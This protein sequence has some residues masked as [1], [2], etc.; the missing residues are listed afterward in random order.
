V[1]ESA[2]LTHAVLLRVADFIKKLPAD[3]LADLANGEAKLELVPKGGRPAAKKAAPRPAALPKAQPDAAKVRAD[4][5]AI[6]E[7]AAAKQYVADLKL[8]LDGL[9]ALAKDLDIALP[10]RPTIAKTV[11]AIVEWTVGR[12]ADSEAISRRTSR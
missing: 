8:K 1:T 12:A 5:I 9:K 2:D 3:Q 6:G 4:L 11:D 10:S 7:R